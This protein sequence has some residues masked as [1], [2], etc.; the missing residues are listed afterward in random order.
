MIDDVDDFPDP[1]EAADG[2]RFFDVFFSM[3]PAASGCKRFKCFDKL[4][5]CL[6]AEH[7]I[8]L[9][10][11]TFFKEKKNSLQVTYLQ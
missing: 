10:K 9:L 2:G 3:S 11:N 1:T 5:G 7:E 4:A 6:S 8:K